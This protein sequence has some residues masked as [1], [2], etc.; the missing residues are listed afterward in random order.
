MKKINLL[1]LLLLCS[2]IFS[3]GQSVTITPNVANNGNL[4]L[5]SNS[6]TYG[7]ISTTNFEGADLYFK[8][9]ALGDGS[10][11]L[12]AGRIS[13]YSDAFMVTGEPGYNLRLGAD[14]TEHIRIIPTG[15]V[16]IGTTTPTAKLEVNGFT[17]LGSASAPAIKMLKLTG[18]TASSDGYT[19]NVLHGLASSKILS[20]EVLVEYSPNLFVT[21]S[22][23]S[24]LGSGYQFEVDINA[25]VVYVTNKTGNSNNILLKPYRVLITYEQ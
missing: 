5:K 4:L 19:T 14:G 12:S 6:Y 3:F 9:S 1:S 24:S 18:I 7:S 21:A 15:L 25:T 22:H 8:R 10:P 23:S 20:V 13:T 17:K 11:G 16:G 2:S